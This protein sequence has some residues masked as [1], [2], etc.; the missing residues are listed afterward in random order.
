MEIDI[1]KF[2]KGLILALILSSI[3]W[4]V[5]LSLFGIIFL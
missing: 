5:L 4:I 1:K 2:V 3:L